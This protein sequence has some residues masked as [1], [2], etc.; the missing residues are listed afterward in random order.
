MAAATYQAH[1][2]AELLGL[3]TW[4]IYESVKNGD[5]PVAP[6]RV[7]RRIVFSK[8]VTDKLLGMDS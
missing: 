7:G 8:A 4:A 3:S 6:I 2:L 5:C 1:E